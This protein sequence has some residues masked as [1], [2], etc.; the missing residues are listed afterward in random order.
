MSTRVEN[1]QLKED[2]KDKN[3]LGGMLDTMQLIT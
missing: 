1:T 2:I 3:I